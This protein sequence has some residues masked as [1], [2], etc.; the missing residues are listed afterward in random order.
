MIV[1]SSGSRI[2]VRLPVI[3]TYQKLQD[4]KS[5]N[6]NIEQ[7]EPLDYVASL[8]SRWQFKTWYFQTEFGKYLQAEQT[9]WGLGLGKNF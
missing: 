6:Y 1:S 8:Y 3:Y 4:P 5:D 7:N 9:Y 2:G